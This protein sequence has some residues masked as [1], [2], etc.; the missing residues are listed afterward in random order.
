MNYFKNIMSSIVIEFN[1][2]VMLNEWILH[3]GD[4]V[5]INFLDKVQ[6]VHIG[7]SPA[8][9]NAE[10]VHPDAFYKKA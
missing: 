8:W 6:G 3:H 4:L 2:Y 9:V 1:Q 7:F 5:E 10:G